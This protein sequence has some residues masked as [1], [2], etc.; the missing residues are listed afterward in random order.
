MIVFDV[1]FV[2]LGLMTRT[3]LILGGLSLFFV[4]FGAACSS[5]NG[6]APPDG[7][8]GAAPDGGASASG[9]ASASGGASGLGDAGV[10]DGV[11][12]H[13]CYAPQ[14]GN[15]PLC[16]AQS[17]EQSAFY[18]PREEWKG[19]NGIKPTAPFGGDP[20]ASCSYK[21]D[22]GMTATCLCDT[23]VH[24]LCTYPAVP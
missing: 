24:W 13:G 5:S 7:A 3:G 4:S 21:S 18:P 15:H 20:A 19:C 12:P 23:G 16:P 17:P 8:G 9:D 1:W 11:T 22:A 6:T 14:P 10:C 2:L